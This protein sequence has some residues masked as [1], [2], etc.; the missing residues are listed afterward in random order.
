MR[1]LYWHREYENV[2]CDLCPH[3]C[4]IPSGK[5][6]LCRVR[7]HVPNEGLEAL[8]YGMFSSVA[9]DPMEKSPYIISCRANLSYLWVPWGAT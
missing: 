8:T 3:G 1:A 9:M 4:L 7:E 2:R 5:R 6:G